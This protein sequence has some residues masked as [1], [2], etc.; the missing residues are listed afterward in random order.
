[1][2]KTTGITV[3][4]SLQEMI[5]RLMDLDL[6]NTP[7]ET[8]DKLVKVADNICKLSERNIRAKEVSTRN[9]ECDL[10][11][12]ELM[13]RVVNIADELGIEFNSGRVLLETVS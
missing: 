6:E 5:D 2:E 10:K 12:K 1:M 4:G 13:L 8:I 9:R 7:Q 3:E 11:E